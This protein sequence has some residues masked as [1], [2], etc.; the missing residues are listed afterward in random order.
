MTAD[1]GI[2]ET[3]R[4]SGALK[5][6]HFVLSS[7]R[8]SDQYIEKFDLL[9]QPRATSEVCRFIAEHFRDQEIDVIVGPTTGGVILAFEVARQLDV[10]AAYA[11]RSS[12]GEARR[13]FRRG[14]TFPSGGRVLVVD[15]ILTTGGS[16]RE[17]LDA[18]AAHPVEVAGVAVLVDRSGGEADLGVRFVALATMDITTWDASDCPMCQCGQPVVKPGTT[19]SPG[20]A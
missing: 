18:L 8:H 20:T 19:P 5:E 11:E 13:E 10:A 17:T 15:D 12:D 6:G 7:G 2:L 14:T 1:A 9:R 16:I 3:L 4:T